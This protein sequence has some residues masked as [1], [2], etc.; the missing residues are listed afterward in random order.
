[1]NV[2]PRNPLRPAALVLAAALAVQATGT[3]D[4]II[5]AARGSYNFRTYLKDEPIVIAAKDG[6]ATLTGTVQNA[7]RRALAEETVAGLP[8][9]K[10]VN[11]QL[12]IRDEPGGIT[13]DSTLRGRVQAALLLHRDLSL[14]RTQVDA[15]NGVVTLQGEA[16]SKA[17]R[18]LAGDYVKGL[19]GVVRVNNEMTVSGESHPRRREIR[20]QIDDASITAQIKMALLFNRATSALKTR[21]RTENGVVTLTGR[22][23]SKAERELVTRIAKNVE[24]IRAV[25]NKLAIEG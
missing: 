22:V 20:K 5:A 1:M 17:Q 15:N 3:D 14:A 24:G 11:N 12:N 13:A 19:D 10:S 21:V 9:V 23:G 18:K 6:A 16:D 25:R 8:A 2:H 4:R 7:F